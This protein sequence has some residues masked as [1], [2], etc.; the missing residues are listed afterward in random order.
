MAWGR[1]SKKQFRV[2]DGE[3][4]SFNSSK[5][6]VRY[7]CSNCGT[8]ILYQNEMSSPDVDLPLGTLDNPGMTRPIYHLQT[9]EKI[10]WVSINDGLDQYREWHLR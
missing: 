6:V 4:Q 7:F 8:E 1:I 9:A 3:P 5:D 10:E 2:I